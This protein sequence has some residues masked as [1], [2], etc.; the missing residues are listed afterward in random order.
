MY[1]RGQDLTKKYQAYTFKVN[2][3]GLYREDIRDLVALTTK[4][5]SNYQIVVA[6]ELGF[7]IALIGP[8][9]L[10]QG[11]PSWIV[12]LTFTSLCESVI[13]LTLALWFASHASI[14]AASYGAR[15]LTQH[16]RLPV[17]SDEQ[18]TTAVTRADDFEDSNVQKML[19]LPF[20]KAAFKKIWDRNT[21]ED[22]EEQVKE[23]ITAEEHEQL[24]VPLLT[25]IRL[26]RKL[27]QFW[28]NFDAYSRIS[29]A[30]GTYSMLKALSF[31]SLG[32]Y[33]HSM[34][35]FYSGLVGVIIFTSLACL[36]M[37]LDMILSTKESMLAVV[38][39]ATPPA[40]AT[41]AIGFQRGI[42]PGE[43]E[44]ALKFLRDTL[45][46][47]FVPMIHFVAAAFMLWVLRKAVP[48]YSDDES[49]MPIHFRL[50]HFLD[51]FKNIRGDHTNKA[52]EALNHED[53][54]NMDPSLAK[55]QA[56]GALAGAMD[57]WKSKKNTSRVMALLVIALDLADAAG[58]PPNNELVR[59]AGLHVEE[60]KIINALQKERRV[61]QMLQ[62]PS[63]SEM[64]PKK[65]MREI[66]VLYTKLNELAKITTE[67]NDLIELNASDAWFLVE[68]DHTKAQSYLSLIAPHRRE[69]HVPS[70]AVV[71]TFPMIRDDVA[72][73][74]KRQNEIEQ[75]HNELMEPSMHQ[76]LRKH[77][78]F[79]DSPPIPNAE[80]SQKP[81][82]VQQSP[83]DKYSV[84]YM[85]AEL[86]SAFAPK[87]RVIGIDA[88]RRRAALF[89]WCMFRNG[90][91][92]TVTVWVAMGVV[93]CATI[94][95]TVRDFLLFV[96]N[97]N[98][99]G[100]GH[101]RRLLGE[102]YIDISYV[103]QPLF[104]P[105]TLAC[106][107]QGFV[108]GNSYTAYGTTNV[109]ACW[110][111]HCDLAHLDN[112]LVALENNGTHLAFCNGDAEVFP[113]IAIDIPLRRIHVDGDFAVGVPKNE[114]GLFLFSREDSR[115]RATGRLEV[116]GE[117]IAASV[118]SSYIY[119]LFEKAVYRWRRDDMRAKEELVLELDTDNVGF[120]VTDSMMYFL[121]RHRHELWTSTRL[122][123]MPHV[124][125]DEL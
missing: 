19:R 4:K 67:V 86:G 6:L 7:I 50:V 60:L 61:L 78:W 25:H 8:A 43:K 100:S 13:Y 14:S 82:D 24:L 89:P 101:R 99:P 28:L 105:S 120:C 47:I 41:I 68:D 80:G 76:H 108:V 59:R 2:Q 49:V 63:F 54:N 12:W 52:I 29:L 66:E 125:K 92:I 73:L 48:E 114:N 20:L 58:L 23:I 87:K 116:P 77:V 95:E 94:K 110:H 115:F 85:L 109:R 42:A 56:E 123:E 111:E 38:L 18:L 30:V 44:D 88:E 33:V 51:M 69:P 53:R 103:T 97:A 75:L 35:N 93:R 112:K 113:T 72:A 107:S 36:L 121:E 64:I 71:I 3:F 74:H 9:R 46:H 55:I 37:T 84:A 57:E 65:M 21:E 102:S 31:Y 122:R 91:F 98:D 90:T 119:A 118:T 106:T 45:P 5:T 70:N 124:T 81:P 117:V 15:L 34:N 83:P 32:Y 40:L 16:I 79:R 17:P 62:A 39:F 27:Q 104:D 1:D 96:E 26:Y 10:Q 11:T 22:T